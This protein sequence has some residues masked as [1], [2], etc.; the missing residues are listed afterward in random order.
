MFGLLPDLSQY[1]KSDFLFTPFGPGEWEA[2]EINRRNYF[3]NR[4]KKI[5]VKLEL[6]KHYGLYSF[7]STYITKMYRELRKSN[8]PFETKSKLMLITGHISMA[9]LEK[10]LRDID[11][12]L[13]ED[14]SGL[15][16]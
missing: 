1:R 16:K 14:Y 15:L 2:Q 6:G 12:E 10:Y 5:K 4:F 11:V 8:S 9:A 3:S 13:P 7:R